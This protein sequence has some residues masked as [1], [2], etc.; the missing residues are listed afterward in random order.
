[1]GQLVQLSNIKIF[2]VFFIYILIL[3][4]LPDEYNLFDQICFEQKP[5]AIKRTLKID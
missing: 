5:L 2:N 4:Q 3:T 1:M